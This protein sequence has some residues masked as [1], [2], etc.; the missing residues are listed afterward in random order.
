MAHKC[1]DEIDSNSQFIMNEDFFPLYRAYFL[2][3]SLILRVRKKE[4]FQMMRMTFIALISLFILIA[5]ACTEEIKSGKETEYDA[6]KKMVVDILQTEDGKKALKELMTDEEMKKE[7]IIGS[8][9]VKN[10]IDQTLISDKGKE[11]W[12]KL[13]E[14]PTFVE[15]F[16]KSMSEEQKKLMK[17]LMNDA[18]F[19]KQMLELLQ[20]P[21]MTKQMLGLMKSQEFRSHLEETIQQTL[22][23]PLFQA[24]ITEILLKAAE[25]QSKEQEQSKSEGEGGG[26]AKGGGSDGGS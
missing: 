15:N 7:L 18:E 23:T 17:G 22:E 4:A 12:S 25:K 1:N 10:A 16:A 20:D 13:F 24:K 2:I 14:D 21:E 11:M 6:T 26:G 5:S 8:D 19:Q 3:S 9:V